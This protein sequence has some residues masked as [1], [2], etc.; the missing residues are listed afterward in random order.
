MDVH[1]GQLGDINVKDSQP[2]PRRWKRVL[3]VGNW[4]RLKLPPARAVAGGEKAVLTSSPRTHQVL[5]PS[6]KTSSPY[7][8]LPPAPMV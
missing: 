2:L 7:L 5:V 4:P 1:G 8:Y 3:L 6:F